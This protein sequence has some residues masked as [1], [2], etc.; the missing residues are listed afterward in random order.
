MSI[1]NKILQVLL[2]LPSS[3]RAQV[4]IRREFYFKSVI[5]NCKDVR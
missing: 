5:L 4:I 1:A 3:G 2:I